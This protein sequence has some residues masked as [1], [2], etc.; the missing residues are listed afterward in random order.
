MFRGEGHV[1]YHDGMSSSAFA[2]L[3]PA[4]QYVVGRLAA[5]DHV[6]AEE[7]AQLP[8]DELDQRIPG[9]R[10]AY[11]HHQQFAAAL[12]HRR[13]VAPH[14][15]EHQAAAAEAR[16]VLKQIDQIGSDHAA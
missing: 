8:P 14:S 2:A 9:A 12:L 16:A 4:D 15:P 6:P 10:T 3:P 7:L 1:R 5:R 11:E 13:G